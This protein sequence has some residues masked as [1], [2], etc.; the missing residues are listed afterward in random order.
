MDHTD[1]GHAIDSEYESVFSVRD[2]ASGCQLAWL[3]LHEA[4]A[5]ETAKVL[6]DLFIRYGPPLVIKSDNGSPLIAQGRSGP[7]RTSAAV[8]RLQGPVRA[9]PDLQTAIS[10]RD[11]RYNGSE[12]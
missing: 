8:V 2:L 9:G 11:T 1:P 4:T 10:T 12:G 3:P 6:E 7:A 5:H